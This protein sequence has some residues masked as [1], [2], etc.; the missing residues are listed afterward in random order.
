MSSCLYVSEIWNHLR[1]CQLLFG[2]R[3]GRRL[4]QNSIADDSYYKIG[5]YLVGGRNYKPY[6]TL[7]LYLFLSASFWCVRRSFVLL[8]LCVLACELRRLMEV[9][10]SKHVIHQHLTNPYLTQT[11]SVAGTPSL[12]LFFFLLCVCVRVS[13]QMKSTVGFLCGG[14][15]VELKWGW[16]GPSIWKQREIDS[17]DWTMFIYN[18]A[19][20]NRFVPDDIFIDCNMYCPS[21]HWKWL[22]SGL[23]VVVLFLG[24]QGAMFTQRVGLLCFIPS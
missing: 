24:G 16:G 6:L 11:P 5:C 21:S 13:V 8:I 15:F 4:G 10:I 1:I 18:G 2:N 22:I 20:E 3:T 17:Q 12:F 19:E 23:A 9:T 7:P 14:V